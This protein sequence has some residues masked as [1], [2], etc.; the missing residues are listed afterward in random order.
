MLLQSCKDSSTSKK[1]FLKAMQHRPG[2]LSVPRSY[3]TFIKT[4]KIT[5]LNCEQYLSREK[6]SYDRM[7]DKKLARKDIVEV[8]LCIRSVDLFAL[9]LKE[10]FRQFSL[11]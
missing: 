9:K 1:Y 11:S 2:S 10:C 4:V 3:F 6:P 8:D 7:Y 5:A